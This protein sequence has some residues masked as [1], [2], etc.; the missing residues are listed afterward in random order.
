MS[1]PMDYSS[2]LQALQQATPFDLFRLQVGIG[3]LLDQPGRLQAIKRRLK[4]G[5][6]IS[7][8]NTRQNR[9]MEAMIEE[10]QRTSVHVQ[11]K[12]SGQRWSIP[13]YTINLDG[14]DTDIHACNSSEKMDKN[15]LKTGDPIGYHNRKHQE[16]YGTILQL[17]P[18]TATVLTSKGERWRVPYNLL[19]KVMD[20]EKGHET[21]T[22]GLI[23]GEILQP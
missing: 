18:K 4:P 9:L 17:N 3:N 5:M 22:A 8:F 6:T 13:L 21:Q 16:V 14:A 1:N 7:Y 12:T 15:Q 11:D 20:G 2:I 23:E 19:F 10:V